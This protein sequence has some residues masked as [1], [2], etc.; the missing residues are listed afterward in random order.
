MRTEQMFEAVL[1]PRP[2]SDLPSPPRFLDL[3][4]RLD[5]APDPAPLFAV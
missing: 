1:P 5:N 4:H 2:R 3:P